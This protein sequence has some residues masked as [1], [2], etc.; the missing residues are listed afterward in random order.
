[1]KGLLRKD[2]YMVWRYFKLYFLLVPVL[3]G[4]SFAV[5]MGILVA[6]YAFMFL[7]TASTTLINV[8][9]RQGWDVYATG[10][11]CSRAQ[12][13]SVKYLMSLFLVGGTLAAYLAIC[14][15]VMFYRQGSVFLTEVLG[16]AAVCLTAGLLGPGVILPFCFALGGDKG[17]MAYISA[18]MVL[19]F[20]TGAIATL[21][22]KVTPVTFIP[23]PLLT[24]W[25]LVFPLLAALFALSWTLSVVLY[26]RR[27]L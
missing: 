20:G 19:G 14:V 17:R 23:G 12:L 4:I 9:E 7:G 5:E 15:G 22:G 21:L 16:V 25:Y 6:L 10:L 26:K 3:F 18:F 24:H 8:D 27:E 1:M 11:P 13:V 2:F